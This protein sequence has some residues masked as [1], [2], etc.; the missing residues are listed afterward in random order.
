MVQLILDR[1]GATNL[2]CTLCHKSF[3]SRNGLAYHLA[4]THGKLIEISGSQ[5]LVDYLC[6]VKE[7]R[8]RSASSKAERTINTEEGAVL[9]EEDSIVSMEAGAKAKASQLDHINVEVG[10]IAPDSQLAGTDWQW[11]STLQ[12][13]LPCPICDKSWVS[14]QNM[15]THVLSHY[16]RQI[17]NN[18]N[19]TDLLECVD[20]S[21]EFKLKPALVQ[22]LAFAHDKLKEVSGSQDLVDYLWSRGRSGGRRPAAVKVN[23]LKATSLNRRAKKMK[24]VS[25][26]ASL[27]KR[28]PGRP[29]S[30]KGN[31]FMQNGLQINEKKRSKSSMSQRVKRNNLEMSEELSNERRS[32]ARW[33]D[34]DFD[35]ND[36]NYQL[37][38]SDS[39]T[40]SNEE[41]IPESNC[42]R[43][44]S[45]ASS[46]SA[47][48]S[49]YGYNINTARFNENENSAETNPNDDLVLEANN[50]TGLMN[51]VMN[52]DSILSV[53]IRHDMLLGAEESCLGDLFGDVAIGNGDDE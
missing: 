13:N 25:D 26:K 42:Y 21:K 49:S 15:R 45:S 41:S 5:D 18:S 50:F 7:G 44:Y 38:N 32:N 35:T 6:G 9:N 27:P 12:T 31:S 24:G 36:I 37:D 34:S 43:A 33:T 47:A 8:V 16:S 40:D 17:L 30:V 22:H 3:V 53:S 20:C 19:T 10:R 51:S 1:C 23:N 29:P 4:F 52:T 39:E 2:D 11:L 48:S 28:G 14:R 46:S